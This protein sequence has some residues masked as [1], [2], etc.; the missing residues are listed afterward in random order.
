V[1]SLS[2]MTIATIIML[3][4]IA[5]LVAFQLGLALG[6]PW[7]AMAYG[8]NWP[9]VLPKGLRINSGVFALI[10]YPIV[11]LY[12]LDAGG[13]ATFAWL[14]AR[15]SVIGVIAGFFAIG[16]LANAFSRSK[17]ERLWAPV[18]LALAVCAAV[19]ALN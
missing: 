12:V 3:V 19:I 9:G 8:G 11:A 15:S 2:A 17:P 5:V 14:P 6:K 16:T 4:L 10:M 7:G 1:S 18:S 13:L